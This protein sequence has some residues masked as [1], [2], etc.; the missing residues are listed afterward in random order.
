MVISTD[1]F[2]RIPSIRMAEA[3]STSGSAPVFMY[4]FDWETPVFDG[5]LGAGHGVD[6]PF[7]FDNLDSAL[8]ST[9]GPAREQLAAQ[10]SGAVLE[11]ARSGDPNHDRLPDWPRYVDAQRATMLFDRT[12]T[13]AEDPDG[14][15]RQVWDDVI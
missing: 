11:L 12:S 6:Y 3:C 5:R 7:F 14:E 8:V 10:M 4:R 1:Y 2:M 15:E 13:L 9:S